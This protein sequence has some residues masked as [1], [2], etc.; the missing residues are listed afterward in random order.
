[1]MLSNRTWR[2]LFQEIIVLVAGNLGVPLMRPASA[3]STAQCQ[4]Q[5][6]A[7][8]PIPLPHPGIPGGGQ[9][10][11]NPTPP[12]SATDPAMWEPRSNGTFGSLLAYARLVHDPDYAND[13]RKLEVCSCEGRSSGCA[14]SGG[15][16]GEGGEEGRLP[17]A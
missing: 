3:T 12:D 4:H 15:R 10:G 8:A 2:Q 17:A 13:P 5:S 7:T 16:G 11:E 6:E 1:M 14:M 9:A